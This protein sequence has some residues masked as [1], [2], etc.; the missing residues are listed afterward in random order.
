MLFGE[1]TPSSMLVDVNKKHR[2]KVILCLFYYT[3]SLVQ[4]P[5]FNTR[6]LGSPGCACSLKKELSQVALVEYRR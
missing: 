2:L 1:G 6:I 5:V 3:P 4:E